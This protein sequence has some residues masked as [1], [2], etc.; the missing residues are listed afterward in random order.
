MEFMKLKKKDIRG[1]YRVTVKAGLPNEQMFSFSQ[2]QRTL[3]D[4]TGGGYYTKVWE[5]SL[6]GFKLLLWRFN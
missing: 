4:W 6:F 1:N 3:D 5:I 2:T